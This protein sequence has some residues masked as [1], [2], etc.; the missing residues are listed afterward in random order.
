[1]ILHA[2]IFIPETRRL[3]ET[4]RGL[5]CQLGYWTTQILALSKSL[6][7]SKPQFFIWKARTKRALISWGDSEDSEEKRAQCLEHREWSVCVHY[8]WILGCCLWGLGSWGN[9]LL[10]PPRVDHPEHNE[11]VAAAAPWRRPSCESS[12]RT[13]D[14]ALRWPPSRTQP[15]LRQRQETQKGWPG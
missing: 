14:Q 2:H 9:F 5:R 1:M 11:D 12:L 13:A 4:L 8:A 7:L 3:L 15:L 10:R 6:N